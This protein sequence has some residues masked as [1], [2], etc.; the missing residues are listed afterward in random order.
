[1]QMRVLQQDLYEKAINT[2]MWADAVVWQ[3][4]CRQRKVFPEM[5]YIVYDGGTVMGKPGPYAIE[6]HIDNQSVVT[7]V[8]MLSADTDYEGGVNGFARAEKGSPERSEKLKM[9]DAVFFHGERLTHWVYPVTS[10]IRVI[11]QC[12]FCKL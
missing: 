5:E 1:M 7:M 10:G 12:E 6:P 3:R 9:G 8:V 4:L 11:L 2:M